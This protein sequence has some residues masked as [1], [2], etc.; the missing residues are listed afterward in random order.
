MKLFLFLQK[1][2]A[3][4]LRNFLK[5]YYQHKL[6]IQE[7][8][9][10]ELKRNK[11][12]I[13][14]E[15]MEKETYKVAKELIEKYDPSMLRDKTPPEHL[16]PSI[17]L[18]Q[19]MNNSILRQRVTPINQ[20]N[21]T[22]MAS[23]S[24]TNRKLY[25]IMTPKQPPNQLA[26][27]DNPM[28]APMMNKPNPMIN[29]PPPPFNPAMMRTPMMPQRRPNLVRPVCA[30]D[31]SIVE[32]F[33]DYLVGDGPNNRY[34]LICKYCYSHNGMSLKDEFDYLNFRCCFCNNLNMAKKQK[35]LAPTLIS[36]ENAKDNQ[37]DET[38]SERIKKFKLDDDSNESG[39]STEIKTS[40]AQIEE[41]EDK[42]NEKKLD[43][44]EE[45]MKSEEIENDEMHVDD[46]SSSGSCKENTED[47]DKNKP[48]SNDQLNQQLDDL[49][50]IDD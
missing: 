7:D 42:L 17:R 44:E 46:D 13:L 32:K 1:F 4:F 10:H 21:Q 39:N 14:N 29:R 22:T 47:L 49:K 38:I 11:R 41:I 23:L 30:Q 45:T 25:P 36:Y 27:Q 8:R 40:T 12:K 15:I 2:R 20:L 35:P 9:L 48:Q 34:A 43:D 26:I 6:S 18:N 24:M 5:S 50:L 33:V 19:S 31:R 28:K 16:D 37:A 3:Y